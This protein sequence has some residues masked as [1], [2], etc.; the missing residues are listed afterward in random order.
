MA[1]MCTPVRSLPARWTAAPARCVS[2][3]APARSE[4]LVDWLGSLPGSVSVAY[5]A[6]PTGFGL[7]R[8]C[9]AA[10]IPCPVA[11]LSLIPHAAAQHIKTDRRDA[12]R[13]AKLL[14]LGELTTVHIPSEAEEAA[15]DLAPARTP[16]PT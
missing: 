4:A 12:L 3:A 7:A 5:E 6:G 9:R 8:A 13:L 14:R 1:W 16:A 10:Q 2:C 15:R 11:A